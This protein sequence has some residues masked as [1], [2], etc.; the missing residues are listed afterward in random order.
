MDDCK[1]YPKWADVKCITDH[2]IQCIN[3]ILV[4]NNNYSPIKN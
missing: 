4:I 1:F 2:K 3:I